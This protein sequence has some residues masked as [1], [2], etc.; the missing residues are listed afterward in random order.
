MSDD[1]IATAEGHFKAA[2][3]ESYN[4]GHAVGRVEVIEEFRK[5]LAGLEMRTARE[6]LDIPFPNQPAILKGRLPRSGSDQDHVLQI[7]RQHPGW[8]G[9]DIAARLDGKV[10]ERTV[11]TSLHRLKTRGLVEPRDGVWWPVSPSRT[12]ETLNKIEGQSAATD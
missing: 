2:M 8:R 9:V 7:I 3:K 6:T 1:P 4:R 11:R 10:H 5:F 12:E